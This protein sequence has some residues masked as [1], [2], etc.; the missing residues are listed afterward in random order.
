MLGEPLDRPCGERH[1]TIPA[2]GGEQFRI[3]QT[4]GVIDGDMDIFPADAA[5]VALT[6]AIAGDAVADAFDA[7]GF[8]MSIWMSS[9]GFSR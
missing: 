8:L 7:A 3:G 4:R 6:G 9:P 2:L 5:L 1:H